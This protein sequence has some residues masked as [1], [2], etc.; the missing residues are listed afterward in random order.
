MIAFEITETEN[1]IEYKSLEDSNSIRQQ[2]F[3]ESIIHT[4]I[5][6]ERRFISQTIIKALNYH[7]LACLHA[8][9]GEYRPCQVHVN[10]FNPPVHYRIPALMDDFTNTVNN[11]W[12]TVNLFLLSAYVYWRLNHIHPFI[13]GNG[14]TSRACC[15]FVLCVGSG[16]LIPGKETL[17]RLLK[18][19]KNE[20]VELLKNADS[21][22]AEKR[23]PIEEIVT[24]LA[25]LIQT[26][27]NKQTSTI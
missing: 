16:G 15:Y 11:N 4:A 5:R 14:R 2:Y 10:E 6:L 21:M 8:N 20:C 26:L 19:N 22:W 23:F 13:N 27:I 7:A 25:N 12:K 3:L 9:A 24:P 1:D 17:P 18:A